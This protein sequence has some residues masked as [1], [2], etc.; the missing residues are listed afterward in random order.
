MLQSTRPL[1]K[2]QSHFSHRR[3]RTCIA[4]GRWV[5]NLSLPAPQVS[6]GSVLNRSSGMTP[7]RTSHL[8]PAPWLAAGYPEQLTRSYLQALRTA[9]ASPNVVLELQMQGSGQA[10]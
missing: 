9:S 3:L 4:R 5:V 8:D 6:L 2:Q 1:A 7:F 10:M